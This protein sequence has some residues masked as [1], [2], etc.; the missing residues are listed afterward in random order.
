MKILT[1][2][3][4]AIALTVNA[5]L[6]I[7]QTQSLYFPP[8]TGTVW[9]TT[10]PIS[11]GICPERVD[12]L[13]NFLATRK[14]KSFIL[15]QGG[16]I[17][18]EKYF[19][20][21]T[22]D[23][24]WYWASAAK[25]LTAFLVGQAQEEGLLKISDP[26]AK[27]LGAGWTS[28][29]P[30][31]EAAITVRHQLTMTTGLNDLI[32][33]DNCTTPACLQY[34]AAP[35]TRWAYY[36]APYRL[37]HDV[38]ANASG[39]TINQFTQTRL[40]S[41]VGMKGFWYDHI[42]YGRA[43]DMARYGLLTL[44]KGVWAGDTLLH[45]EAYIYD[46]THRSQQLNKSYGYLWWLNG[47]E[48]FM[49]PGLQLVLPGKLIPNAPD[50]MFS[51]LGKNDQKI[52]IVPSKGWIVVRQGEDA[53]YVGPGGGQVPIAFDND[54]WK[55]LNQLVCNPVGA[56]EA[57]AS[58]LRIWPNPATEGWSIQSDGPMEQLELYDVRGV[59]VRSKLGM[60]STEF[61]LDGAGLPAGIF[62]LKVQSEGR[63][64][65][66]KTVKR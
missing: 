30:A 21:Y 32:L 12:S 40:L 47:Q 3:L 51:A 65:W 20:T 10:A 27:Y 38:I 24:I 29:T 36:N 13:Y 53:G 25:S 45:N 16:R 59:L 28:A 39:L 2:S 43:R 55:Y 46:M 41:K 4:L 66:G 7:S 31:Q 63:V 48:S 14:T 61:W 50:D 37:L 54:L 56:T 26:T 64:F 52:H 5:F 22:Q 62:N 1:R 18:L 6:G 35:G 34:L 44:A 57:V 42:Q 49:L 19:G 60:G 15:L 9:Q 8:K 17:V 33:D 11:L 58:A 23:S